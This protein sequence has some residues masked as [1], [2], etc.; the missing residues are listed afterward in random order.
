MTKVVGQGYDGCS[1]FSGHITGVHK[2][3]QQM[4]P[5]AVYVHCSAHK[6]NLVLSE[7]LSIP[8]V[9]NCL[10]TLSEVSNLLRNNVQASDLLKS[11]VSELVPT[12]KKTRLLGVCQTRFIERQDAVNTF[13]ELLPAVLPT[14]QRLSESNR[15]V[16]STAS[17]LLLGMEKS[18]FFH[19]LGY[20]RVFVWSHAPV[21]SLSAED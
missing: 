1:T 8:C 2:R 14:L 7:S 15:A 19:F 17:N 5:K 10:G 20:L 6:L 11:H 18:S 12:S 21:S 16:S 3:V 4:Y 13:I 9:R